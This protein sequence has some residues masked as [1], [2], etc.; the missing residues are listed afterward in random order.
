MDGAGG[1]FLAD[2]GLGFGGYNFTSFPD[3]YSDMA[4][5]S[6]PHSIEAAFRWC[7]YIYY[8]NHIFAAAQERVASY[9]LTDFQIKGD[10]LS[11]EQKQDIREYLH[12]ELRL[13]EVLRLSNLNELVYGNDLLSVL[14]PFRRYLVCPHCAIDFPLR[15][16]AEN[17]QFKYRWT[18]FE[19]CASCPR[20]YFDG[21]WKHVDRKLGTDVPVTLKHW[22][23]HEMQLLFNPMTGRTWFIWMPPQD[24]RRQIISG[25]LAMLEDCPWEVIQAIK[26]NAYLKLA[27]DFVYHGKEA[28]LSGIYNRGWG[29]SRTIRTFRQCW[30]VQVLVRYNEAIAQDWLL[31]LRV[32]TPGPRGGASDASMDPLLGMNMAGFGSR[33]DQMLRDHRRDPG[34]WNWLPFPVQYQTLGGE[35]QQLAPKDLLDQGLQSLLNGCNVPVQLF[36]LDLT[37]N[38]APVNLRLFENVWSHLFYNTNRRAQWV[39]E[40]VAGQMGWDGAKVSLTPVTLADDAQ[41]QLSKLQLMTSGAV[42]QTTGLKVVG[43]DAEEE[44]KLKVEEQI[45][46]SELQQK[47]QEQ[48]EESGL[49]AQ[50]GTPPIMQLAQGQGAQQGQQDPS[51]QQQ[52]PAGAQQL[53]ANMAPS[54]GNTPQTPQDVMSQAQTIASQLLALPESQKDSQLIS[55]KKQNPLLHS[56]VSSIIKDMRRQAQVQGGAQILQQQKQAAVIIPSTG[57]LTVYRRYLARHQP[58]EVQ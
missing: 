45:Q 54:M 39:L 38:N 57:A 19:F 11:R 44:N 58:S 21:A 18:D 27:D 17:T 24:Y 6:M 36:N 55:L 1:L 49:Q 47:A 25:K 4:S 7:E 26:A 20:C 40:K 28:T 30:Y 8:H 5:L 52:Q 32:I 43:L 3:P 12:D 14:V 53:A 23:I 56:A 34:S 10:E 16:V 42:S 48:M 29:I 33:I 15:V 13:M 46:T 22:N 41:K 51:Q 37:T 50:I 9:P 2:N 35:A 31:P